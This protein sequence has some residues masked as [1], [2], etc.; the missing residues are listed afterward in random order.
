MKTFLTI[1]F[2]LIALAFLIMAGVSG[3]TA[4]RFTYFLLAVCAVLCVC[5]VHSKALAR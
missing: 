4:V 1:L 3:S 5:A 2:V